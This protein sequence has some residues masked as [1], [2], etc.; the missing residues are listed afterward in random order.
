M[1]DASAAGAAVVRAHLA[2]GSNLGDRHGHL[3]IAIAALDVNDTIDVVAVSDLYETDP[4]GGPDQDAFLNLVVAVDTTLAPLELLDVCQSLE[5]A[6]NRVRIEHWGPRTLDVDIVLFGDMT[7]DEPRLTV[8]HP[9]MSER[10]FVI[11]PL[12]DVAPDAVPTDWRS[13][14][15]DQVVRNVGRLE[16]I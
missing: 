13:T 5:A 2:L 11:E 15:A 7:I 6:A 8:P 4:I 3:T 16:A 10:R 12:A 14:L 9:R 1:T